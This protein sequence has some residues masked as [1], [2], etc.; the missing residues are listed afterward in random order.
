MG[1]FVH[2]TGIIDCRSRQQEYCE[3]TEVVESFY[4]KLHVS[5]LD[6]LFLRF[7]EENVKVLVR[8]L[9]NETGALFV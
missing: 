1:D 4:N 2:N 3:D 8:H 5:V 7:L 6:D 9:S